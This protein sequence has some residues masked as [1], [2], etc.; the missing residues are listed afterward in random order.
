MLP[1]KELHLYWHMSGLHLSMESSQ[2]EPDQQQQDVDMSDPVP[3]APP[4]LNDAHLLQQ[5]QERLTRRQEYQTGM[6]SHRSHSPQQLY[7]VHL[8]IVQSMIKAELVL[9][10]ELERLL[11]AGEKYYL[12]KNKEA[13]RAVERQTAQ[14]DRLVM[15]SLRTLELNGACKISEQYWISC[16]AMCLPTSTRCNCS[17]VWASALRRGSEPRRHTVLEYDDFVSSA[18]VETPAAYGLT[19]SV[20]GSP[21][22]E[23]LFETET[24]RRLGYTFLDG[25]Y[26]FAAY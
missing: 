15:S 11:A 23:L 24:R 26:L 14:R 8:K 20:A 22:S 12:E 18:G 10:L 5:R 9:Q 3:L 16:S 19:P 4:L 13:P 2:Q 25:D 1:R 7:D 21:R 17:G 6:F